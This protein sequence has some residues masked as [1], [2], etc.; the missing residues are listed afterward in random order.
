MKVTNTSTIKFENYLL[1]ILCLYL[2]DLLILDSHL[3]VIND[4]KTMLSAIFDMK[5]LG[6][7]S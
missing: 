3:H 5:D 4:V 6:E 2:D 7:A 1:T